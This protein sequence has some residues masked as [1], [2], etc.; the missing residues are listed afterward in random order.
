MTLVPASLPKKGRKVLRIFY[1]ENRKMAEA[2]VKRFIG[3]DYEVFD[4]EKLQADDL[5]TIFRGT[6]L[7][8]TGK[9]RILIKNL[10]ENSEAWEKVPEYKDT[11]H[12][13]AIW[14]MKLDGRLNGTKLLKS[15]G[16]EMEEFKSPATKPLFGLLNMALRDGEAA[17]RELEKRE[18]EQDPYLLVGLLVSDAIKNLQNSGGRGRERKILKELADL[19]RRM[20]TTSIEPWILVKG[21]LLEVGNIVL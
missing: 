11:E 19:D 10:S 3:Q 9:R 7:F 13:V 2:A 1:G 4:G 15:A 21:F 8:D 20:K 18:S 14:E 16:I 5:P 17:V 6:S 12:D